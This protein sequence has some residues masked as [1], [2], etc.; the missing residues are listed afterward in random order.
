MKVTWDYHLIRSVL[1]PSLFLSFIFYSTIIAFHS[2]FNISSN[3]LPPCLP[4]TYGS[5]SQLPWSI[6]TYRSFL[7]PLYSTHDLNTS[8][9]RLIE[10]VIILQHGNLRNANLD[11]CTV[12]N[13]IQSSLSDRYLIIAPQFLIQGDNIFHDHHWIP[14]QPSNSKAIP[15]FTS[16]GWKEGSYNRN[17]RNLGPISSYE[18]LNAILFHLH[19]RSVFP[20]L[21]RITLFGFSAGAQMLQRFAFLSN[22]S[23]SSNISIQY[24]I[25]NPSSYLYFN[26]LRPLY[27]HNGFGIPNPAWLRDE[28]KYDSNNY[29]WIPHWTNS[30]T[31]YNH[32]RFGLENLRG[33]AKDFSI[34][35]NISEAIQSYAR[36]NI[37][38]IMGTNDRCNCKLNSSS[39]FCP[40][41]SLGTCHDNDLATYCQG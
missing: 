14:S 24:L 33:Y 2:S 22:D 3:P 18:I 32:W 35:V 26:D 12:V 1:F 19:N 4:G 17:H 34:K 27:N 15:I 16:R 28:W 25:S 9:H 29:T 38:Y 23:F 41:D 20:N 40:V 30:C 31:H 6:W 21:K 7:I 10:Q 8:P 5:P 13:Q 36:K 11:Y 37:V 39:A